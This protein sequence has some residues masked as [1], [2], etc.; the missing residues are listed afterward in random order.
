MAAIMLFAVLLVACQPETVEVV[1]EVPVEVTRVITE[2][3]TESGESLEVTRIITEQ[4]V[5]TATP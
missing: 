5:V 1:K 2:T 3:V 4:V